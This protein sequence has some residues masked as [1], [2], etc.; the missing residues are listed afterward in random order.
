MTGNQEY[1]YGIR[2]GTV[3]DGAALKYRGD[4]NGHIHTITVDR[5]DRELSG[6]AVFK[7]Q[8]EK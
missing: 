3:H 7:K 6:T 8:I 4:R 2:D 1:A 5:E